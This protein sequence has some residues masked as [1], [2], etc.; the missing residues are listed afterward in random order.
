[1]TAVEVAAPV[2]S[3]KPQGTPDELCGSSAKITMAMR[4]SMSALVMRYVDRGEAAV[5]QPSP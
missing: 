3:E 5:L 2:L 1:M 4:M